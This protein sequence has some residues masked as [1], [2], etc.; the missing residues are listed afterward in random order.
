MGSSSVSSA[1]PAFPLAGLKIR[2]IGRTTIGVAMASRKVVFS[3]PPH[4]PS[5]SDCSSIRAESISMRA[6]HRWGTSEL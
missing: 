4:R 5:G 2:S 6:W 1:V 3:G